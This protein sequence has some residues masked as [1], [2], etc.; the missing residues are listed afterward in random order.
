MKTISKHPALIFGLSLIGC[1]WWLFFAFYSQV[2][3]NT[4]LK[5]LLLDSLV[6]SL[7]ISLPYF[8]VPRKWRNLTW[9][10]FV[11]LTLLFETNVVFFRH[12]G[13]IPAMSALKTGD[14][15]N[16][17]TITGAISMFRP[18][19]IFN[20]FGSLLMLIAIRV[21]LGRSNSITDTCFPP[22]ARILA[23]IILVMCP[24]L[25]EGAVL[26]RKYLWY[27]T[28]T[29]D[30]QTTLP[31]FRYCIE[32]RN[33]ISLFSPLNMLRDRGFVHYIHTAVASYFPSTH[34]LTPEDHKKI[35]RYLR[36]LAPSAP[37]SGNA[38]K[39]LVL[40][41]VESLNTNAI[42]PNATPFLIRSL[43]ERGTLS[44]LTVTEQVDAGGSSDG[45]FM[46]NT[47]L[48][49][50][51]NEALVANYA[52]T[53]YPSL[54]KSLNKSCAVELLA[55][56]SKVWNHHITTKSYGYNRIYDNLALD[57]DKDSVIFAKAETL[58]DSLQQPFFMEITTISMHSPY[59]VLQ[60]SDSIGGIADNRIRN[61][62]SATHHFDRALHR[63]IDRLK[64]KGIYENTVI[65]ITGDHSA[66]ATYLPEEFR[67]ST[68]PLIVINAGISRRIEGRANQVDVFPTLLDIM[69]VDSRYRGVGRSLTADSIPR[70][71]PEEAWRVS[72][73]LIRARCD[74]K[75]LEN[76]Y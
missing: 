49:P 38:N 59:G 67:C 47:G 32:R 56:S 25:R 41:I 35:Q 51:R 15:F 4:R 40:I 64:T 57:T 63:F 52:E 37:I 8:I 54:A 12:F 73:L 66:P 31:F 13:D 42:T 7:L 14:V 21:V 19:D 46:I 2:E 62:L 68:V 48:L 22:A 16:V 26:R 75:F 20:I 76:L 10:I 1:A 60:V 11:A 53:S 69:G 23:L 58:L 43:A 36:S 5:P 24:I 28:A 18:S 34:T 65:A 45:Q 72:E 29:G 55:E 9:P 3:L 70:P 44:A 6:D 27:S 61:Y 74:A 39:N 50:L 30:S 33:E 71:T 17:F